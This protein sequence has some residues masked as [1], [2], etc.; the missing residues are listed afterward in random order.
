MG[1]ATRVKYAF[2]AD[3]VLHFSMKEKVQALGELS[4][5]FAKETE[6]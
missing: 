6:L 1:N 3:T 2:V 4:E 5:S